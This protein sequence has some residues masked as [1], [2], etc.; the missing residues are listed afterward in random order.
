[1]FVSYRLFLL[2]NTLKDV[3]V[4][5]K[6]GKEMARNFITMGVCVIILYFSGSLIIR[7]SG[8]RDLP[9]PQYQGVGKTAGQFDP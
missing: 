2:T 3:V 8:L 5:N 6:A 1:M 9:S 4:P 7:A